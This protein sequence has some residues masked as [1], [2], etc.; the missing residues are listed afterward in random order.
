VAPVESEDP[1]PDAALVAIIISGI[2][3]VLVLLVLCFV[4]F[5]QCRARRHGPEVRAAHLLLC[6]HRRALPALF[7]ANPPV[8]ASLSTHSGNTHHSRRARL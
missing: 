7:T 1:I 2:A 3:V 4:I 5:R 6:D 8:A